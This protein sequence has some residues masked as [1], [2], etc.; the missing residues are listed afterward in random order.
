MIGV[1]GT[2]SN[3]HYPKPSQVSGLSDS[4]TWGSSVFYSHRVSKT[5]YVGT[6]YLYSHIVG[7]SPNAQNDAQ[8]EVDSTT[9]THTVFLFYSI[10]LTPNLSIS[11]SGG[12][13]YFDV[14]QSPF[15]PLRSWTPAATASMGWQGQHAN[16]A[17]SYSHLVSAGGGLLGA[18]YSNSAGVS[19]RWQLARTWTI[20]PSASYALTENVSSSTV[21]SNP[22][23]N[24]FSG[25]FTVQH[26]I[27]EHF[28][29]EIGYTRLHQSYSNIAVVS[30]A[31]D[32]NREYIAVSYQFTR[33]LGR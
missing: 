20:G 23:G 24:M 9:Q 18:Y 21:Q 14:S 6:T 33:P 7:S 3:L 22:G 32:S 31:P 16:F 4:D 1:S 12:P 17:A 15:S 25:T 26:P 19:A 30:N 13:E 5:Q 10:Y 27:S 8:I 28:N 2:F 11:L 29:M